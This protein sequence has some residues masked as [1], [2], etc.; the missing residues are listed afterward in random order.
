[1]LQVLLLIPWLARSEQPIVYP[2]GLI[3][4]TPAEQ[5]EWVRA[6]VEKRTG[7][8]SDFDISFYP[9]MLRWLPDLFW[10]WSLPHSH[11]LSVGMVYEISC[12]C[13]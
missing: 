3:F 2:D 12:F 7:F 6:W 5:A 1:M 10:R 8:P 9:G 11:G 13:L 4:R